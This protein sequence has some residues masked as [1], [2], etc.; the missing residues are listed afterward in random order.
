MRFHGRQWR[1]V[2]ESLIFRGGGA[3][4]LEFP[5][6]ASMPD[7]L[8]SPLV[9]VTRELNE[10]NESVLAFWDPTRYLQALVDGFEGIPWDVDFV[11]D[12]RKYRRVD[13]DSMVNLKETVLAGPDSNQEALWLAARY[14]AL[15]RAV[16][17]GDVCDRE[18]VVELYTSLGYGG[19]IA[20]IN[21][22]VIFP[23][24]VTEVPVECRGLHA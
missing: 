19:L 16:L 4:M 6:G 23:V 24:S 8:W 5:S 7:R 18:D 15:W 20:A 12:E 3:L 2:R 1:A 22:G 11:L 13:P 14:W 10:N 21:D 17:Q 9:V